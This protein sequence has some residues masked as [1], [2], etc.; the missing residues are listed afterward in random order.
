MEASLRGMRLRGWTLDG[1][2]CAKVSQMKG[3]RVL[4]LTD[5]SLPPEARPSSPSLR[6]LTVE[7]NI[8]QQQHPHTRCVQL[9]VC[10]YT[11]AAP[12]RMAL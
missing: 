3:L 6:W 5:C 9:Q 11:A 2:A 4:I 7:G 1:A 12:H 10:W 8:L